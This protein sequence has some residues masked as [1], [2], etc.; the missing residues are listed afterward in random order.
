MSL[1]LAHSFW[2]SL[3][4]AC[5]PT[6]QLLCNLMC[7]RPNQ[8]ISGVWECSGKPGRG[9]VAC[10]GWWLSPDFMGST[11]YNWSIPQSSVSEFRVCEVLNG[12]GHMSPG[13][14]KV[15]G[16]HRGLRAPLSSEVRGLVPAKWGS[17]VWDK[18]SY[19]WAMLCKSLLLTACI[20]VYVRVA[21]KLYWTTTPES[22]TSSKSS[23]AGRSWSQS[24]WRTCKLLHRKA[25]GPCCDGHVSNQSKAIPPLITLQTKVIGTWIC[26]A[27]FLYISAVFIFILCRWDLQTPSGHMT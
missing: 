12:Q 23:L 4:N 5:Y 8:W 26:F 2:S 13:C 25:P 18:K 6:S 22:T 9:F 10:H 7:L 24:T 16:Q 17:E 20:C 27:N 15:I 11:F 1:T 3:Q 14:S 21:E 19:G